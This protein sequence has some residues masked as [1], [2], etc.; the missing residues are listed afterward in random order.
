MKFKTQLF[1][2][3]GITLGLLL[4]IGITVFLSINSLQDN[5]KWVEFTYKVIDKTNQLKG[6][7]IDQ[8][9]GLNGFVVSGQEE[10][11]EPYEEGKE[12]FDDVLDELKVTLSINP[13]Q[14]SRLEEIEKLARN[15]RKNVAGKFIELRRSVYK[16]EVYEREIFDV[17]QSGIGK[18]RMDEV[19]S[20]VAASSMS[21]NDKNLI[22]IDMIN[23][24][25][26]LRGFLLNEGENYL[27]PYNDGK[28]KLENHL[29]QANASQLIRNAAIGWINEYAEKLI[30]I[31]RDEAKTVDMIVLYEEFNK[32]EGKK[33][34][35]EIRS[36]VKNITDEESRLLA[37]R[38][39]SQ[40]S[41]AFNAKATVIGGTLLAF[42]IGTSLILFITR[43]VMLTLGGEPREV[44]DMANE[45]AG[46]NLNIRFSGKNP[47]GLYENMK[48]MV[49]KLKEIVSEVRNGANSVTLASGEMSN[50]AQNISEGASTQ[51][52]SM[53][54]ISS[55]ME[56]MV[57][58]I[59]Q[60]TDNARQTE[61]M[62]LKA[63]KDVDEGKTAINKTVVSMKDIAEKV[64]II[65][66]I[67]EKTDI[68]ALNAAVE[69]ARAG[70]AG[71]GFAIVA[72]E[73]RKLAE[74][75]QVSA[76]EIEELT[77][78]SVS[79]SET[80]GR[81]FEDL[82]PNIQKTAQLVQEINAASGEQNLGAQ[83]VNEA[84]QQLNNITQQNAAG[85]EQ[86]ASNSEELSSQADS[87]RS[88]INYFKL[89]GNY[90]SNGSSD[91]YSSHNIVSKF[92]KVI[93]PQQLQ[94]VPET[95]NGEGVE[96]D[97]AEFNHKDSDF[98]KY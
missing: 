26:G 96:L 30:E 98:E 41:T 82:V 10:W 27:E 61:T 56:Q 2:G 7:M 79:I 58:N 76:V 48:N 17:I 9:T 20:I 62:A 8:E 78:S 54:E 35:D 60:N 80:A 57:A 59:Q 21:E 43:K 37:I 89:D 72:A 83:Q 11:M 64:T 3:N 33:I 31:G 97:M 81:L 65:S 53:E 92:N 28:S 75:S 70:E 46:G 86:L 94:V 34:I 71:K 66:E 68:L 95:L 29:N 25:T 49:V 51:A 50:S 90:Q 32:A 88:T 40:E 22:I 16:G 73:V 19:R 84:I 45:V 67:A 74:R 55:S 13:A 38:L 85:A 39:E 12:S 6:Y 36:I 14:V 4:I 91:V 47:T 87:M 63:V 44:A 69:A 52:A 18:K 23:M 24:E 93:P 5:T 42:I 15:W 77:K 1:L